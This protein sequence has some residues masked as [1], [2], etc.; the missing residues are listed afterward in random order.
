MPKEQPE[1][2]EN[3]VAVVCEGVGVDDCVEVDCEQTGRDEDDCLHRIRIDGVARLLFG[4]NFGA[5]DVWYQ[6]RETA[7]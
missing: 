3:V 1:D 2:V 7:V 5:G 6:A 4:S